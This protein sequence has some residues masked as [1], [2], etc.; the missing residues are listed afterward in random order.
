MD[1]QPPNSSIRLTQITDQL[2]RDVWTDYATALASMPGSPGERIERLH[3]LLA[4]VSARLEREQRDLISRTLQEYARGADQPV[5][6][7]TT[8]V[9]RPPDR[10]RPA[11]SPPPQPWESVASRRLG[12]RLAQKLVLSSVRQAARR[13]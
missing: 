12:P 6:R 7:S 1:W 2:L 8:A 10:A 4:D 9:S 5:T 13:R 11:S 3:G